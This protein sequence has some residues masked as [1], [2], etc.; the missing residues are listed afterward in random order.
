MENVGKR[1]LFQEVN[2]LRTLRGK[3]P[4]RWFK[5]INNEYSKTDD[6]EEFETN[7]LEA[8][9]I[10]SKYNITHLDKKKPISIDNLA[11]L[12]IQECERGADAI[13]IDHLHY[14]QFKEKQRLDLEITDIMQRIN[15][16]AIMY[17]VPIFLVSHYNRSANDEVPKL[18][19][20]KDASAITQVAAYTIQL[21]REYDSNEVT[22]TFIKARL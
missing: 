13:F 16:I 19:D 22:F 18:T 5:F 21:T 4:Y 10:L 8:K 2:K 7:L 1:D 12:M 17:N 3:E 9:E 15:D 6:A 20:F 11:P 14:F